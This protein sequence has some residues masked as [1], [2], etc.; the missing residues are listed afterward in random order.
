M[1]PDD[2]RQKDKKKVTKGD[3]LGITRTRLY[4]PR[5]TPGL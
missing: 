5:H 2:E 3:L 1:N 4:S